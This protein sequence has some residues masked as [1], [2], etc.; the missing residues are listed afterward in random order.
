MLAKPARGGKWEP[1]FNA[2]VF[3]GVLNSSSE[4]VVVTEQGLV[5]KTCAANVWR[6]PESERWDADRMLGMR[7][8]PWCPDG[9]DTALDIQVGME[10][11]AE[12]VPR[13]P[14]KVLMEN[15][16]TRTYLRRA[17]F[18]QWGLS[19]GCPGCRY[20]KSGQGPQQAHSEVRRS[21]DGALLR[22]DS[23][24][25]ARLAAAGERINRA[26]ADAVERNASKDPG[27]RDMLKRA[28]V[29]CHPESEPPE[30]QKKIPLYTAQASPPHTSVSY[31][32]SSGSGAHPC[33]AISTDQNTGTG[34]VTREVRTGPAQDVTRTSSND[35]IGD[36]VVMR[37]NHADENRAE[38]WSSSGVRQQAKNHNEE[39]N[40]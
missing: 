33:V 28:S 23:S 27:T 8:V 32:G 37:E 31:G 11:P 10:R 15:E 40:T 21:R 26:L 24:G 2:G 38:H 12:M 13:S 39:G 34:G 1:R 18:E 35:D 36:D 5:S 7:A 9:S 29:V 14:G 20:L 25:S 3:I 30:L 6:K 16:V 17:D 19:E 22:G 4:A